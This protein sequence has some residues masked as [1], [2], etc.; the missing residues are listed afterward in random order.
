MII[1]V[2]ERTDIVNYFTPR[3]LNRFTEGYAYSRNPFAREKVY[4]LS[5]NPKM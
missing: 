5:L 3:L 2:G 1:N 4:K